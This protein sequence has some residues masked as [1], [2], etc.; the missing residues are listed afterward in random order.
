MRIIPACGRVSKSLLPRCRA[1]RRRHRREMRGILSFDTLAY[2]CHRSACFV[3]LHRVT[4]DVYTDL[5][6]EPVGIPRRPALRVA[7]RNEAVFITV[8]PVPF[9]PAEARDIAQDVRPCRREFVHGTDNV[10]CR[11][12]VGIARNRRQWAS[13]TTD[14][15]RLQRDRRG[16]RCAVRRR[17]WRRCGFGP[18]RG[19]F[20]RLVC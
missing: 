20:A 16:R 11:G 2:F 3:H 4:R 10:R 5:S 1:R 19:T 17:R 7:A 9:A 8:M 18:R 15:A 12:C 13:I 14:T 6:R